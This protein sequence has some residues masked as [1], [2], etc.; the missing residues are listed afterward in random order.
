[1][2]LFTR[3][4]EIYHFYFVV[5]AQIKEIFTV[6]KLLEF[7]FSLPLITNVVVV[8]FFCYIYIR[9]GLLLF[10]KSVMHYQLLWISS[11]T[12]SIFLFLYVW[13]IF[14]IMYCYKW[15][16][17]TSIDGHKPFW[18]PALCFFVLIN[19]LP[20]SCTLHAPCCQTAPTEPPVT[21]RYSLTEKILKAAYEVQDIEHLGELM[22][23]ILAHM[24]NVTNGP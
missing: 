5:Q 10:V 22:Q 20:L 14:I 2:V 8:M 19:S 17:R 3:I 18:L 16:H 1:M 11:W 12:F 13:M 6:C 9:H 23:V 4:P 15:H 21:P 7:F 24:Y